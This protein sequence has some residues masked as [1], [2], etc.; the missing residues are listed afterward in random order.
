MDRVGQIE[1]LVGE[2]D[3]HDVLSSLGLHH[4]PFLVGQVSAGVVLAVRIGDRF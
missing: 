2:P 3:Q 1:D 4:P